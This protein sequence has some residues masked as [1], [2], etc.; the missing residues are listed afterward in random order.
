MRRKVAGM[1]QILLMIAVVLG[2]SVL[3][4]D[5]VVITDFVLDQ[6][7]F[8]ATQKLSCNPAPLLRLHTHTQESIGHPHP[9]LLP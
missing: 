1:K 7:I 5:D 3:A 8:A 9:L 4:A 6:Q 2:Q